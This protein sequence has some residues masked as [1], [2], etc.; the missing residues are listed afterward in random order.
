MGW[1]LMK[2]YSV[3][4]RMLDI[5]HVLLLVLDISLFSFYFL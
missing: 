5:S 1:A 2:A 4:G 3:S